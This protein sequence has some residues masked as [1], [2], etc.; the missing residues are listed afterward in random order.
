MSNSIRRITVVHSPNEYSHR[1]C[2]HHTK[3]KPY[4]LPWYY[5]IMIGLVLELGT[6]YGVWY[7]LQ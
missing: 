2:K 6:I 4:I 5:G 3:T 7:L 1:W